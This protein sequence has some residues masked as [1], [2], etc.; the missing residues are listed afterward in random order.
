MRDSARAAPPS[1]RVPRWQAE[2]DRIHRDTS[3]VLLWVYRQ[4]W[5]YT[6]AAVGMLGVGLSAAAGG[7][8]AADFVPALVLGVLF[9]AFT[10]M[11]YRHRNR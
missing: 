11:A 5:L 2:R 7:D 9:L 6:V 8:P 4:W 10:V 3:P 1:D